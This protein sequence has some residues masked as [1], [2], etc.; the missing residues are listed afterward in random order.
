MITLPKTAFASLV[1]LTTLATLSSNV[2]AVPSSQRSCSVTP[3][4]YN[5]LQT[6]YS[7]WGWQPVS[8]IGV[9]INNGTLSRHVVLQFN[10]DTGVDVDA[11]VRLGYSIDNGPV[12]FYGPQN[13]ANHTQYW[14]TR[15]NLSV[16]TIGPGVHTIKPY[17]RVSGSAGKSA[18]MDDRC[19]VVEGQTK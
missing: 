16:A 12:Q 11:E 7:D 8:G 3:D 14:E 17:W 19:F 6:I 9:T 2:Y 15:S 10:A 5:N 18:T 4:N 13:F 1:M